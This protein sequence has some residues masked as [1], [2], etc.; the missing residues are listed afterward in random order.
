MTASGLPAILV[1]EDEALIRE[2]LAFAFED[3][4]FSVYQ[5]ANADEALDIL[6][7]DITFAAVVTDLRMPG[8]LDGHHLVGWLHVHRAALPVIVTS[9]Y[10]NAGLGAAHVVGKPYLPGDVV[11]LATRLIDA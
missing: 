10:A 9:G 4:D 11:E 1:V 5:A 7:S 8:R 2:M 3:A 6:A